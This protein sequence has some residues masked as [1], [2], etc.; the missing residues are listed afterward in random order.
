MIVSTGKNTE[1]KLSPGYHI[2]WTW[3]RSWNYFG[4]QLDIGSYSYLVATV[5]LNY[6]L[7]LE[8]GLGE[9]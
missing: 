7:K 6:S 2:Q 1:V 3:S 9:K 4:A 8:R 5:N